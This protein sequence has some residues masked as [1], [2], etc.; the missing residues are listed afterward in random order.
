MCN[1]VGSSKEQNR[2]EVNAFIRTRGSCDA[3]ID[4]DGLMKDP[5]VPTRMRADWMNDCYHPNA[6]GDRAMADAIDLAIFGLGRGGAARTSR[7]RGLPSLS[8]CLP[9]N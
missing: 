4:W 5:D 6:L 8:A 2:L 7:T 9:C 3:V 1:P